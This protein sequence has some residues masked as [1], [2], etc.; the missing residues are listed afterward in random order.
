M[1]DTVKTLEDLIAVDL[2]TRPS[3]GSLI[4]ENLRNT[5][6]SLYG[7]R[8][9]LQETT[10][11]NP[12]V[13]I[14][15]SA[16]WTEFRTYSGITPVGSPYTAASTTNTLTSSTTT[17]RITFPAAA[18]GTY[19]I[20]YRFVVQPSTTVAPIQPDA[21]ISEI[22][23]NGTT[24][25]GGLDIA[26][27]RNRD[28]YLP[29]STT[30]FT[31][32]TVTAYVGGHQF[33]YTATG[34][35]LMAA[36]LTNSSDYWDAIQVTNL[37]PSGGGTTT[38]FTSPKTTATVTTL[39]AG[40][41]RV[42]SFDKATASDMVVAAGDV[43]K[44]VATKNGSAP[45]LQIVA[46]RGNAL[47]NYNNEDNIYVLAGETEAT[48]STAGDYVSVGAVCINTTAGF[49]K[50]RSAMFQAHRIGGLT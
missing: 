43:L 13:L 4:S 35:V 40:Q 8:A 20:R 24:S 25:L 49:L 32:G 50:V 1:T 11:S 22:R 30:P 19:H 18:L 12:E 41:A 45:D 47:E 7:C 33:R 31:T 27:L 9:H 37:G 42:F 14:Q 26:Y 46:V 21:V 48:I 2:A 10:L 17:G 29:V 36:A 3:D 23:K 5:A 39:T 38:L 28:V 34:L 15:N 6:K 16:A 44:I